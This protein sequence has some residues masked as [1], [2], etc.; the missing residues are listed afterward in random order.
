MYTVS[1]S[2]SLESFL[3]YSFSAKGICQKRTQEGKVEASN[4]DDRSEPDDGSDN[5]SDV[6]ESGHEPESED[7]DVL[8][9]R[10]DISASPASTG[11]KIAYET[12]NGGGNGIEMGNS[13]SPDL[14]MNE[15]SD[16]DTARLQ[17]S[18]GS[19]EHGTT[20]LTH[21]DMA[22]SPGQ[23]GLLPGVFTTGGSQMGE[24]PNELNWQ[25][26]S[27]GGN[28]PD[29]SLY[30]NMI[31]G[32]SNE[33]DV[34][35]ISAGT[36]EG[37]NSLGVPRYGEGNWMFGDS[38]G[39]SWITNKQQ[40]VSFW[41]MLYGPDSWPGD[42]SLGIGTVPNAGNQGEYHASGL[43]P[44]PPSSPDLP[45]EERCPTSGGTGTV[46]NANSGQVPYSPSKSGPLSPG[47]HSPNM[48][49]EGQPT[50]TGVMPTCSEP[51]RLSLQ[52]NSNAQP[53]AA[54]SL[55]AN[56]EAA[57]PQVP[58]ER[59]SRSGRRIIPS[60]RLEKMNE[61]GSNVKE[62]IRPVPSGP[63][64]EWVTPAKEHLLQLNLGEGWKSCVN[65]WL[66]LEESLNYGTKTK[67]SD[68]L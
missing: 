28:S 15:L 16:I 25:S 5:V 17:S 11:A 13:L 57:E 65:A 43:L 31:M 14:G 49:L 52:V 9:E 19:W 66:V 39:S 36:L 22:S 46:Q 38:G 61:I 32:A 58:G 2:I 34:T 40:N 24:L 21:E 3:A 8:N 63:S 23:A 7:R 41:D 29:D 26:S 60:T 44:H 50:S 56:K 4:A 6:S 67:V 68:K 10:R 55:P 45:P 27:D 18:T 20:A 1:N 37:M 33:F 12:S 53:L 54:T 42:P 64:S 35:G 47:S 30:P 62:N 48:P 59:S 51:A